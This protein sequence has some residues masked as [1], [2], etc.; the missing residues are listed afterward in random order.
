M[1]MWHFVLLAPA[2]SLGACDP[3][4]QNGAGSGASAAPAVATQRVDTV[5]PPRADTAATPSTY[6]VALDAEGLRLVDSHTGSTRLLAFG[7]EEEVAVK[8]LTSAWGAPEERTR[9]PDCAATPPVSLRWANGLS[10]LLQE[11][12]FTGWSAASPRRAANQV[13]TRPVQTMSGVGPGTPRAQVED[14]YAITV[15]E[16][17]LGTEFEAGGLHGV[18]TNNTPAATVGT[19]WAGFAC[20]YR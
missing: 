4:P 17:T 3:A 19:L 14:V 6:S 11:G 12:R 7:S 13:S 15:S 9:M 18:F 5:I 2:L 8:A 10:L 16:T 1:K 20:V